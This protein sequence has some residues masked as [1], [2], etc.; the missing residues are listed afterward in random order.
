MTHLIRRFFG[1]LQAQPLTPSEQARVHDVL[2]PDLRLLF[3]AQSVPD[4]RH[5]LQVADRA[6]GGTDRIEAALLHDVG[7]AVSDLGAVQR[8]LATMWV[9][10]GLP[11]SGNWLTYL[12]HGEI[13]AA[14]LEATGASQLS[15]TFARSHPGPVPSGIDTEDWQALADADDA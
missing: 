9:A 11:V 1:Y 7:K 6:K 3:F 15:V 13:G 10:T 8:S 12:H 14:M 5:A 2:S 4:Q